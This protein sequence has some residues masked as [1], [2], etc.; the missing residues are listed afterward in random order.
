MNHPIFNPDLIVEQVVDKAVPEVSP[1][2]IALQ[3][4]LRP[5][6]K[7][8]AD[9]EVREIAIPHPGLVFVRMRGAWHE[10][11]APELTF[12]HLKALANTMGSYNEGVDFAPIMSLKLLDGER[13][14]V[15]MPPAVIEGT[16]SINIRK[17]SSVVKSLDELAADG[18]FDSWRNTNAPDE[19]TP[20]D[21][22]L[23]DLLE[24][25]SITQFL[26]RAVLL[27]KNI[28][29]GG[30]TGSGKTTFARSLI[31]LVP[32]SERLITI[33]DV[34]ELYLPRHRNKVH[35]M[36]GAGRGQ[37]SASDCVAAC[38]RSS[39]DRIFLSEL[40][41]PEAWD[42]LSAL[43][44]GHPGSITTTHANSARDIY[45]RVTMLIK[46]SVAGNQMDIDTLQ[47][48]LHSTLDIALY[49]DR[50]KLVEAYFDPVRTALR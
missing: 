17:H 21:R 45:D 16:I 42:Y 22:E 32:T 38:M 1:D 15:M 40:R 3:S 24:S 5:L 11:A 48:Y 25:G 4:M 26:H 6:S 29:I 27:R 19:A 8:L 20:A 33:E 23:L 43:N 2:D 35:L 44:T 31:E 13:G 28:I 18:A 41:G 7:Y 9:D 14:Q 50:F 36:Y 39:P 30:K 37:P 10:K 12:G 47:N 46:Q 34:H 49:F